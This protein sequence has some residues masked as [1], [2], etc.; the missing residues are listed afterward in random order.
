MTASTHEYLLAMAA[1]LIVAA[2]SIWMFGV[3]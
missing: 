2:V 3:N 1:V